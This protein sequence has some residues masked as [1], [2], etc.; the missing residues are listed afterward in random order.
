[1]PQDIGTADHVR[2]QR[3]NACLDAKRETF[4]SDC[5]SGDPLLLGGCSESDAF[6][7]ASST[8]GGGV[9]SWLFSWRHSRRQRKDRARA[10]EKDAREA[11]GLPTGIANQGNTCYLNSLLQSVYHAPGVKEAV[12]EAAVGIGGEKGGGGE[13]LSALARVF[14]Q[15]D[16]GARYAGGLAGWLDGWKRRRH[17][18][19][20]CCFILWGVEIETKI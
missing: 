14:R 20:G 17:Q 11:S 8:R 7:V 3:N 12:L 15:L 10:E 9:G 16:E 4:G 2:L 6:E 19:V 5:P 18:R 1:M 13:T